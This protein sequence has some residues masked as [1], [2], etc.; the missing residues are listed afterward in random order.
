M[1]GSIGS[2]ASTCAPVRRASSRARGKGTSQLMLPAGIATP[3]PSCA[4]SS[5]RCAG[6]AMNGKRL[7]MIRPAA[8][9]SGCAARMA[10][11]ERSRSAGVSHTEFTAPLVPDDSP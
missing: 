2:A 10:R 11:A 7:R 5:I 6:A 3:P 4:I 1:T 8:K 9:V